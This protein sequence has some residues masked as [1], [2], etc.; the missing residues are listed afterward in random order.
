V[1]VTVRTASGERKIE[2]SHLLVAVGR[3]PNTTGI[4]L[5]KMRV[6]LDGRG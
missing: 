3:V 5:E 1:S 2:G 6:E 4:G